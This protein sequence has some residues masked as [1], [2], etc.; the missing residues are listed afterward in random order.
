[1]D[2]PGS[3]EG[4]EEGE[5]EAVL[6]EEAEEDFMK[7]NLELTTCKSKRPKHMSFQTQPVRSNV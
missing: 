2:N 4:E 1:M 3:G 6:V 7:L 5:E